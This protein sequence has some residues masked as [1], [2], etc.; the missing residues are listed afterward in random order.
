MST[1]RIVERGFTLVELLVVIAIIGILA[2]T[3]LASFAPAREKARDARRLQ[4]LNS[5]RN[6]LELYYAT[7]QQYPAFRAQTTSSNCGTN[8][9]LLETALAPY[10]SPLPRDAGGPD[11]TYA[12]YYDSNT[13]NGYQ[14][15]GLMMRPESGMN[16]TMASSDGAYLANFYEIGAQPRYCMQKYGGADPLNPDPNGRWWPAAAVSPT[17]TVCAGGD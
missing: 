17:A 10:I 2:S 9:C 7:N 8:W 11:A 4:D 14:S 12:Y 6:A 15:Y 1:E 5:I 16:A 13:N 3:V